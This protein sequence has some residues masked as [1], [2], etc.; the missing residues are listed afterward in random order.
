MR[1]APLVAQQHPLVDAEAVLFVDD[2]Q[3]EAAELDARLEQ[4]MSADGDQIFAF[5]QGGKPRAALG[6]ALAAGH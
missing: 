4:R 2:G 1:Q 6:G 3:R 5:A